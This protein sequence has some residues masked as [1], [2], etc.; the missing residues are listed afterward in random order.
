MG[1]RPRARPAPRLHLAARRVAILLA[2][3]ENSRYFHTD[4][5][6]I[7]HALGLSLTYQITN[8]VFSTLSANWVDNNSSDDRASY[9][10]TGALLGFNVQY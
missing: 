8:H 5:E 7:R 1:A 2:S 9:Q 3:L 4:R 10:S 6:D